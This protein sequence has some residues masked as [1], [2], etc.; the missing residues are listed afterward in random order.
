MSREEICETEDYV[1]IYKTFVLI[2][3]LRCDVV[4]FILQYFDG[5][6]DTDTVKMNLFTNHIRARYI[7]IQ[8]TLWINHISMRVELYG[9]SPQ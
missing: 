8:V 6:V 1:S 3:F 2:A 9:C 4:I 5:N 7:R